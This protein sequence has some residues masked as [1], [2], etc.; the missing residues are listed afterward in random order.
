MT[1]GLVARAKTFALGPEEERALRGVF[2]RALLASL[3][4]TAGDLDRETAHVM[5]SVL[6]QCFSDLEVQAE[7]V[8]SLIRVQPPSAQLLSERFSAL[9]LDDSTLPVELND[10]MLEFATAS[11]RELEAEIRKKDSALSNMVEQGRLKIL[12]E[13][14][15][16]SK[17]VSLESL[18]GTAPRRP[19]LL[20]GRE[21]DLDELLRR[22][23]PGKDVSEEVARRLGPRTTA[24]VGLPGVGKTSLAAEL[25]ARDETRELFPDGLLWAALGPS[26]DLVSILAEWSR[27]VGGPDLDEYSSAEEASRRLAAFLRGKKMLVVADDVF[28][29]EHAVPLKVIDKGAVLATTRAPEVARALAIQQHIYELRVL[30]KNES[31]KLLREVAPS[32]AEEEPDLLRDLARQLDGL[33]L[34]LQ[35][36]GRLLEEESAYGWGVEELLGELREGR[37][38]LGSKAPADVVGLGGALS[39][40]VEALLRTSYERLDESAREGFRRLGVMAAKPSTFDLT[41]AEAVWNSADGKSIMRTLMRRGLVERADGGRFMMH[42]VLAEFAKSMLEEDRSEL[43]DAGKR[44]ARHFAAVLGGAG[45]MY[46]GGDERIRE[47]ARLLGVNWENIRVGHSWAQNRRAQD[48]DAARLCIQ[49]LDVG[50]HWLPLRLTPEEHVEWAQTAVEAARFLGDRAAEASNLV[51]LGNGYERVGRPIDA[52]GCYEAALERYKEIDHRLG[53]GRALGS[54]GVCHMALGDTVAAERCY[55]GQLKIT[56]ELGDLRNEA[57]TRGNLG[58]LYKDAGRPD[59]AIR[60]ISKAEEIFRRVGDVRDAAGASANLGMVHLNLGDLDRAEAELNKYLKMAR[61][62]GDR[63]S[64]GRALGNLGFVYSARRD[65]EAAISCHEQSLNIAREFGNARAECSAVGSLAGAHGGA[66]KVEEAVDLYGEQMRLASSTGDLRCAADAHH[67][68]GNLIVTNRGNPDV[69]LELLQIGWQAYRKIGYPLGEANA[70]R[71]ASYVYAYAYGDLDKARSFA[72]EALG[73]YERIGS[74]KAREV[75]EQLRR[76]REDGAV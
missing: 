10:L 68:L 21:G 11:E 45:A 23:V 57:A 70:L 28:E 74:P 31:V 40:T 63:E 1:K 43:S 58:V 50:E 56:Q 16:G 47:G 48:E 27:S 7:L 35:V 73:I 62:L 37:R 17:P 53:E 60:E 66:G 6:E 25:C 30:E 36:A 59:D 5:Q 19:D 67:N 3:E 76:W 61:E 13:A 15:L 38:L 42:R 34:A 72:T 71:N 4:E 52:K 44:H 29:A 33:P 22:L 39:P 55:R 32:L 9:G 20:V 18:R 51:R 24:V 12:V 2:E 26:P 69:A 14:V 75:R 41:A 64:E 54:L 65:H 49:Y 46:F 8:D